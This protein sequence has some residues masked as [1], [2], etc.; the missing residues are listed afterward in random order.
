MLAFKTVDQVHLQFPAVA[1]ARLTQMEPLSTGHVRICCFSNK[2]EDDAKTF[3]MIPY[4]MIQNIFFFL[5][6]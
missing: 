2:K 3:S 4:F 6:N 5:R 1:S